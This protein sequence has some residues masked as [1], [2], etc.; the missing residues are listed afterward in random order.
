M[1]YYNGNHRMVQR[2]PMMTCPNQAEQAEQLRIRS[3]YS[4][5]TAML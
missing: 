1:A 4:F 3:K 5:S 2:Q